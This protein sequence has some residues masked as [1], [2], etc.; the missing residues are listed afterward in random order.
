VVK[1]CYLRLF[2]HSLLEKK[3]FGR[4]VVFLILYHYN[5]D[6]KS[7]IEIINEINNRERRWNV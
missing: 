6:T 5:N 2:K 1:N 4:A 7:I 3:G